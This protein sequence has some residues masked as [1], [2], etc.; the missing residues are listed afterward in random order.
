M[1]MTD[2]IT[3]IANSFLTEGY[4]YSKLY[5]IYSMDYML[6]PSLVLHQLIMVA[7]GTALN[8]SLWY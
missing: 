1:I 8:R 3:T 7:C 4:D 5:V 2:S 6:C